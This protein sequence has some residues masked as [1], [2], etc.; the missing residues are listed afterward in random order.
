MKVCK[1]IPYKHKKI[2]DSYNNDTSSL[3]INI[4]Y[5]QKHGHH[6]W[7]IAW[8]QGKS[9]ILKQMCFSV[10]TDNEIALKYI[11]V[12][13]SAVRQFQRVNNYLKMAK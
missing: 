8:E 13:S 7:K 9:F 10:N 2:A 6:K 1:K 5:I 11:D 4:H 12:R 3:T